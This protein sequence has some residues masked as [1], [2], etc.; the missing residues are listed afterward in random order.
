M[1]LATTTMHQNGRESWEVRFSDL[2]PAG[3]LIGGFWVIYALTIVVRG[4]LGEDPLT[5]LENRAVTVVTGTLLTIAI[6][7]V[8]QLLAPGSRMARKAIVAG[9]GSCLAAVAMSAT[10]M[11]ADQYR[12]AGKERGSYEAK[13][14]VTII[15]QGDQ[16]TF[17]R[18]GADPISLTLPRV[19]DLPD[20]DKLRFVADTSVV[21]LFFFAAWSAVY[22]ASIS[23]RQTLAMSR[24]QASAESAARN[25]QLQAMR[26]QVNPHFLF[27][28]LNSI[29]SLIL[30][31]RGEEAEELILNLSAFFRASL[32]V[33]PV[34]DISLHDE[35][36][37]QRLY[38][39]VEQA[40]LRNRLKVEIELP[41]ELRNAQVPALIL[42]P[43]TEDAVRYANAGTSGVTVRIS[44]SAEVNDRLQIHIRM[45]R[46]SAIEHDEKLSGPFGSL[47]FLKHLLA[48]RYGGA[49]SFTV[50]ALGLNTHQVTIA[51]PK[52]L[53]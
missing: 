39:S 12:R 27:N 48:T 29:S 15:R 7:T 50:G 16:L 45:I 53:D 46:S 4:F 13:D 8:I 33:D 23:Q 28:T 26:Y 25:A 24:R 52:L 31:G 9:V 38:L 49:A 44:A 40:R 42:H 3:M 17:L 37:L 22:L 20:R 1:N 6:Y 11:I 51:L 14:G 43:I 34:S 47:Y 41:A 36:E 5:K 2:R 30:T 19:G 21:W 35:I 10:L 32:A 18:D